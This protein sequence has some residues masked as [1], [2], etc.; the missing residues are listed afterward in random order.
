[1]PAPLASKDEIIDRLFSVFRERG[2][3][4]ASLADLSRGTGLGKSS[5]YHHFPGGKAEMVELV[6]ARSVKLIDD[7]V[8]D[9][10]KAASPLKTRARRIVGTFEQL[11]AGGR[12]PCVLGRLASAEVGPAARQNLH[13]AFEHWIE[14]IDQ[15]ARDS[16]MSPEQAHIFAED[17]VARLQGALTLQAG[18]GTTGPFERVLRS[19]LDLGR[20]EATHSTHAVP[21]KDGPGGQHGNLGS[22]DD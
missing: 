18:I 2:F 14:A 1:M 8:L 21:Q 15:L 10:A 11:F 19:L 7:A 5:L 13:R 20:D 12:A 16:G 9:A 4:G 6:L 17:W 22:H 3:E